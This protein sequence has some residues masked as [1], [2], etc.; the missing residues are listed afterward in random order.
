M[1]SF[2]RWPATTA[3]SGASVSERRARPAR[4][5]LE[6][7]A[8]RRPDRRGG[9]LLCRAFRALTH[10]SAALPVR[11]SRQWPATLMP[12]PPPG[13]W[14]IRIEDV[15]YALFCAAGRNHPHQLAC[16]GFVRRRH[17]SPERTLCPIRAS[18]GTVAHKSSVVRLC[19]HKKQLEAAPRNFEGEAI[20]PAPVANA[21]CHL[22]ATHRACVCPRWALTKSPCRSCGRRHH[23]AS[24]DRTGDFVGCAAPMAS[25]ATSSRW[26]STTNCRA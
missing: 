23:A 21:A 22:P 26:W 3:R 20:T 15:D 25:T 1:T 10:R 9:R 11:S 2:A 24:V 5:P 19:L 8:P 12:R 7:D 14:L 16:Y 6:V 13:R 18:S 17:R 4:K